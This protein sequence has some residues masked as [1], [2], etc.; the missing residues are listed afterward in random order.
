MDGAIHRN[1]PIEL[2]EKE[3]K[4]LWPSAQVD[5]P[6]ILVSIGTAY[7]PAQ[8]HIEMSSPPPQPGVSFHTK[9][10]LKTPIDHITSALDSEKAWNDYISTLQAPP[11][12]LA[13]FVR[14]NPQLEEDPPSFDDV[15]CVQKLKHLVRKQMKNDQRIQQLA[16]KLVAS[17]FYFEKSAASEMQPDESYECRGTVIPPFVGID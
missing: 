9:S 3:R 7:G 15:E 13:R 6:D 11:E 1:N 14:L 16:L 12:G 5:N 4:I 8:S 17:C 10:L 2:A